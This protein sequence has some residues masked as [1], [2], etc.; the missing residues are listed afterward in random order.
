[1]ECLLKSLLIRFGLAAMSAAKEPR[2]QSA[3][4]GKPLGHMPG[5]ADEIVSIEIELHGRG[6]TQMVDLARDLSDAFDGWGV[7]DRYKDGG[8]VKHE[9]V[10]GRLALMERTVDMHAEC[11]L[12]GGLL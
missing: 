4:T 7:S 10:A 12:F 5:P 8:H 1:M 3:G 2:P 9:T 6:V 11:E